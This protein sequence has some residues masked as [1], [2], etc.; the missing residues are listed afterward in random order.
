MLA[1]A[2]IIVIAGIL[3]G[4]LHTALASLRVK[5][6][7]ARRFGKNRVDRY[8]RLFFAF[9]GLTYLP[10]AGLSSWLPDRHLYTIPSPWVILTTLA[11]VIA[12]IVFLIALLQTDVI[13]DEQT[14]RE[15]LQSIDIVSPFKIFGQLA[16]TNQ[17]KFH[18]PRHLGRY[19]FPIRL[20]LR[21][22][23]PCRS[24]PLPAELQR[25]DSIQINPLFVHRTSPR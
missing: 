25:P 1:S 5:A 4:A 21:V 20:D 7:A 8:Y 16:G 9:S 19:P 10:V 12:G 3:F 17:V 11:Q 24:L 18:I 22:F 13:F 14:W 15:F 6:W 23:H 2:S